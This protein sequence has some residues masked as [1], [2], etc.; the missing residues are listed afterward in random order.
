MAATNKELEERVQNLEK[1]TAGLLE[2]LNE[3]IT[4][5]RELTTSIVETIDIMANKVADNHGR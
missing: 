5:N 4:K 2:T 1:V 3:Y